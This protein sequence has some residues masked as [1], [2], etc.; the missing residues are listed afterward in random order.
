MLKGD[1]NARWG[2]DMGYVLIPLCLKK[3]KDPLDSV[4][5]A[6]VLSDRKKTSLE[7]YF[8]Y[9]ITSLVMKLLGAKVLAC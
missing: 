2:N 1:P 4:R 6:K 3:F 9:K 5:N 8:S 7:A